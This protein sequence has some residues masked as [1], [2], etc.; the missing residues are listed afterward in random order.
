MPQNY[1]VSYVDGSSYVALTNVQSIN[2]RWGRQ[3]IT[4]QWAP[5]TG[6]IV[7]R[8]PNYFASPIPQ[9]V[10]GCQI[11]VRNV[12]TN[13]DVFYAYISNVE[14]EYGIPYASNVG[15]LD[16]VTISVEGPFAEMGRSQG[17][18]ST[19]IA[20]L[21]RAQLTDAGTQS[22]VSI[23]TGSFTGA[24]NVPVGAATVS[25]SWGEWLSKWLI[26]TGG[27]MRDEGVTLN[28]SSFLD[29]STAANF[30]D[31]ANSGLQ[32]VY[33]KLDFGSLSDN[34]YTQVEVDP[35]GFASSVSSVG[36]APFRTLKLETYSASAADGQNLA[37][38]Y[39]ANLSN[40]QISPIA[41]SM[42]DEAQSVKNLDTNYVGKTDARCNL[43]FR[44]T[45][46]TVTILG[47]V[48]S[49]TPENMIVTCY[50]TSISG[51][52]TTYNYPITYNE[53]GYFYN[54]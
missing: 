45:T 3:K 37:N 44:G 33:F 32:K 29:T 49:V 21:A 8:A 47:G 43:T 6:T 36:S 48:L 13:Q 19:V 2:Y 5:N 27:N 15:P 24:D 39:L 35:V 25:G 20:A 54:N 42:L 51:T 46:K 4:D 38:Y 16:Y 17:L 26:T 23:G 9:L 1:Q 18:N 53:T 14:A 34:Y 12:T 31:V 10:P 40:S 41:V 52:G 22:G 28:V 50:L 7:F 30:S 11:R